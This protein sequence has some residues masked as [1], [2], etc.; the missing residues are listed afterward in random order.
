[1]PQTEVARSFGLGFVDFINSQLRFIK[2]QLMRCIDNAFNMGEEF[3]EEVAHILYQ[4]LSN[5]P[6]QRHANH[7]G[8]LIERIRSALMAAIVCTSNLEATFEQCFTVARFLARE[9]FD[10][11]E[12]P[13]GMNRGTLVRA[14]EIAVSLIVHLGSARA[15]AGDNQLPEIEWFYIQAVS[16]AHDASIIPTHEHLVPFGE[17]CPSPG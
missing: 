1:M 7:D 12:T 5:V 4:L 14:A 2:G 17:L 16:P 13:N 9:G 11:W 10:V 8:L 3:G 15:L 6:A